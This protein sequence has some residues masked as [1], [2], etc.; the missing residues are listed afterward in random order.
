MDDSAGVADILHPAVRKALGNDNRFVT[1]PGA[2]V[3]I[4]RRHDRKV[5]FT[6]DNDDDRIHRVQS[7]GRFYEE[8]VLQMLAGFLPSSGTF[9]DVGANVGN[10]TLYMSL[11][12]GA[13]RVIPIEPNPAAIR[14]LVSNLLLND[15]MDKVETRTLGYGLGSENRGG[16]AIHN[17][18]NNLGW[19]KLVASDDGDVEVRRGD[20]MLAGENVDLIKV[21]VEG[22]EI[23]AMQGLRETLGRCRPVLFVEVDH[24]NRD[25]FDA[26]M[27]EFGYDVAE[28]FKPSGVNQNLLLKPR[29]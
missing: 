18:K 29:G 20:D 26:L 16:M 12:G 27:D 2:R 14:L 22:M 6:I 19:T 15:L 7:K 11:F 3:V 5:I 23:D 13:G 21:D 25:E 1:P 4:S 24:K 8:K 9:V 10:H 28:S 17:P